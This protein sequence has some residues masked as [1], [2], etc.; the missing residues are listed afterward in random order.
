MPYKK[1]YYLSYIFLKSDI[2][3]SLYMSSAATCL[4]SYFHTSTVYTTAT[5]FIKVKIV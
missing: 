3:H 2:V 5:L 1:I 4:N